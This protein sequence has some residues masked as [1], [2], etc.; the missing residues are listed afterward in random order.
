MPPFL[1]WFARPAVGLLGDGL[2]HDRRLQT[3]LGTAAVLGSAVCFSAKAV[4]VKVA[5]LH[6]ADALGIL[7][8]RMLF[9][10]PFFVAIVIWKHPSSG[11][12]EKR[13]WLMLLIAGAAGYYLASLFDFLGLQYVTAGLER[14][15]LFVYPAI[16]VILSILFLRRKYPAVVYAGMVISYLGVVLSFVHDMDQGQKDVWKGGFYILGSALS[17][18]IF[19]IMSENLISKFGSARFTAL[20]LSI[21]A[22][23]VM[24]HSAVQSRGRVLP[25]FDVHVYGL[26]LA[27]AVISTVIP[28]M[29]LAVGIKRIGAS[30][31]ALVGTAGPVSTISLAAWI[32]D[33]PVSFLQLV[34]TALVIGGIVIVN[35]Q[36]APAKETP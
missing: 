12:I 19:L 27:L 28:S 16:V 30:A 24:A 26:G 11:R 21:S 23:M 1:S 15:I 29:L 2:V 31:S 6:G 35:L 10:L 17:Y 9:S 20:A 13:D 22:L 25:P 8:L 3:W 33:E 5:F 36:K 34:G 14:V 32:L 18:S 4:M 7:F